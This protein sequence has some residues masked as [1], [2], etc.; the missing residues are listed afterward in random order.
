VSNL[1]TYLCSSTHQTTNNT[2]NQQSPNNANAN[3]ASVN[4]TIADSA[5]SAARNADAYMSMIDRAMVGNN[6]QNIACP[7]HGPFI[8]LQQ[9]TG[10]TQQY[11]TSLHRYVSQDQG[12]ESVLCLLPDGTWISASNACSCGPLLERAYRAAHGGSQ[13]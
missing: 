13:G 5:N 12:E 8:T 3:H 6:S 11:V 10:T 1:L 9:P 2:T 7:Y 4:N